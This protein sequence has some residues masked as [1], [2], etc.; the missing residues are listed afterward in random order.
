MRLETCTSF[1][2]S[3]LVQSC[4]LAVRQTMGVD[5]YQVGGGDRYQVG[6]ADRC[7]VCGVNRCWP[8]VKFPNIFPKCADRH[9]ALALSPDPNSLAVLHPTPSRNPLALR[10]LPW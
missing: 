9:Q 8:L 3:V 6:G 5:R 2:R 1:P 7:G 10:N 4:I